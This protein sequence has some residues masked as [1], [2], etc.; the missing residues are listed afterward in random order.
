MWGTRNLVFTV[1]LGLAAPGLANGEIRTTG[2]F[3][4]TDL[5][6][7]TPPAPS[8]HAEPE[9]LQLPAPTEERPHTPPSTGFPAFVKTTGADFVAFP[10]RTSTWVILGVGAASALIARPA[11]DTANAHVVGSPAVGRFFAPGK[12]IGSVWVQ[13]GASIGLYLGGRY[14][15]P[16]VD[17]QPR[18][19]KISHLGYDLLRAQIV[20]QVFVHS[21]KRSV[22][23]DRPT[24][25]CCAF[26]SGHAATAFAAASV[27]ERHLGYRAAWPTLLVATYV[28]VSRLH[29][30]RHFLS[31]IVFGSAVG[32]AS[33]WT[34][35]GRHG[36]NEYTLMPMPVRG[37]MAIALTRIGGD[38]RN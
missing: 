15:V 5:V 36:R 6:G 29:D 10:Q 25:E 21:I 35:V 28:G 34:V 9:V 11:D 33:G 24:G 3:A 19:N 32:M 37:G 22:R 14:L 7:V 1:A 17:G 13:A 12:W 2:L 26:P 8:R 30:N 4:P 31:D 27:L 16:H 23:R 20:S 18:T 38:S